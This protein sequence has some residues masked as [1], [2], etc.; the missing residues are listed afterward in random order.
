MSNPYAKYLNDRVAIEVLAE[1]ADELDRLVAALPAA[2]LAVRPAPA[3]WS[4]AEQLAHLADCEVAFGFRIRQ[5]LAEDGPTVQPFDQDKWAAGYAAISAAEALAAFRA[6]RSWNL[7][8]MRRAAATPE[9]TLH[10][11]ERGELTLGV[12]L[13]LIAGHDLNHRQQ[14]ALLAGE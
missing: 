5:A 14:L 4:V 10:H 9:R 11:P 12:L 8:A 6:L 2:Q 7:H 3:K 13:E 1:T